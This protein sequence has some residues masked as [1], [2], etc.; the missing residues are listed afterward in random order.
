MKARDPVN[1]GRLALLMK[2][3]RPYRWQFL[4]VAVFALLATGTDLLA[5]V[6]YREAI[7]DIAGLLAARN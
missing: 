5:P 1:P 6:I 7:N 3:A 4:L 2:F